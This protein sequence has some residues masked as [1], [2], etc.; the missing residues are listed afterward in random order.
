MGY[1]RLRL[2]GRT[3]TCSDSLPGS[4]VAAV[5]KRNQ[6]GRHERPESGDRMPVH[7]RL[8]PG[9]HQLQETFSASA[10][11][12]IRNDAESVRDFVR[13]ALSETIVV[14]P[15]DWLKDKTKT[16]I[17]GLACLIIGLIVYRWALLSS[18]VRP[19]KTLAGIEREFLH[20]TAVPE[21]FVNGVV[22]FYEN[23]L[24]FIGYFFYRVGPVFRRGVT[25]AGV[26][27]EGAPLPRG[28]W[29]FYSAEIFGTF[30]IPVGLL[31]IIFSGHG[32]ITWIVGWA[33]LVLVL[34][35]LPRILA[36]TFALLKIIVK[37]RFATTSRRPSVH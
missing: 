3:K 33:N 34:I 36:V 29:R 2:N 32:I 14:T 19:I 11:K 17:K 31:G 16:L 35:A 37:T 27:Q 13:D 5:R 30:L 10:S 4:S 23:T 12:E 7:S 8:G 20:P 26:L 25:P 9:E 18:P 15:K 22:L 24:V 28:F 6:L 1:I 21:I